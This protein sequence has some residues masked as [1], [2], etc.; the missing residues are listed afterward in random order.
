MHNIKILFLKELKSYFNSPMAY[1]FLILFA[2]FTGYFFTNTFFLINQSDMRSLFGIVPLIYLFFIPAVTMSLI[3]KENS[4][5][6]MEI[7]S[8]LPIKDSEFVIGKFLAATTLIIIG[9]G[10]TLIHFFTLLAVGTNID[11]GAVLCGYIGLILVGAFYASIGTFTSSLTD[12][13]VVAFIIAIT[14]VLVFFLLDKLLFFMPSGLGG[15]LQFISV[16]YH[17]SNI[18]RGVIDSRNLIYFGSMIA[19]FLL[20]TMRNLEMRKWR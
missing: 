1:I 5:G 6:T 9:L 17:L 2:I 8:T 3:A 19:I 4:S 13:Q 18:S 14:I 16:D 15:L 10:F 7:I 12:N 20:T 11:L